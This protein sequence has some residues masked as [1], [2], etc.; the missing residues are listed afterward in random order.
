LDESTAAFCDNEGVVKNTT[1]PESPLKKNMW[2]SATTDVARLLQLASFGWQRSTHQRVHETITGSKTEG[3]A[4][5]DSVLAGRSRMWIGCKSMVPV[6]QCIQH[7]VPV[8][9]S[10]LYYSLTITNA[11]DQSCSNQEPMTWSHIRNALTITTVDSHNLLVAGNL[12]RRSQSWSF[13]QPRGSPLLRRFSVRGL[14][15][16]L[17][18]SSTDPSRRACLTSYEPK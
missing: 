10:R 8:L 12:S 13:V 16:P 15:R 14:L 11:Q 18:A 6:S 1:A 4:G 9:H 7:P 17:S 3:T 2:Q 5:Q